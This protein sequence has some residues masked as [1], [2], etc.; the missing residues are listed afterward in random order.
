MNTAEFKQ[1]CFHQHD[2]E[3]NQKYNKTMPYSFQW[4]LT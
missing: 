2:V 1:Y 3:C 4:Y